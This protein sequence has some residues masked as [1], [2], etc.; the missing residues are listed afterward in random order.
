[1]GGGVRL[2]ALAAAPAVVDAAVI[3]A[4]VS[5]SFLDNL[6]R[7]T[8]PERPEAAQA[9]FDRFGTPQR[10][11][12]FYRGLSPRTYFDRITEPVLIFHGLSDSTCPPRWSRT[13]HRLLT[14][15][16][17]R[18]TLVE[19]PGEEHAFYARWQD[20]IERTVRFLRNRLEI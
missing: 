14:D 8:I 6:H 17:V 4:S 20:S 11:P 13:T 16:G 5:S 19:Y 7:W 18:N 2:D 3:Y 12:D 15:A 9:F 1:M 10:S